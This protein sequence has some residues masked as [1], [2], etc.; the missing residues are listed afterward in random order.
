MPNLIEDHGFGPAEWQFFGEHL[1][2]HHAKAI[3]VG[4]RI[5]KM[6]L[7]TRLLRTHV[8]DGAQNLSLDGQDI[9]D[10]RTQGETE[11]DDHGAERSSLTT[12]RGTLQGGRG[13]FLAW[14]LRFWLLS[15]CRR[16]FSGHHDV[17]GLDVA[18]NTAHRVGVIEGFRQG[19]HNL[20]GGP[21]GQ[22][23]HLEKFTQ[24]DA[25]DETGNQ[26]RDALNGADLIE[27][28]DTRVLQTGDRAGF[29][30]QAFCVVGAGQQ[31][32]VGDLDSHQTL[33]FRVP[34]LP[35]TP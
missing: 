1:V 23:P 2:E 21:K 24:R 18:V 4:P 20:G 7:P 30:Q 31:A 11:V 5:G 16:L 25:V 33:Q 10:F 13:R 26:D 6:G 9:F 8:R 32:D 29:A 27:P 12:G 22:L 17:A 35:D 14:L 34:G 19:G 15:G 3:D 28:N